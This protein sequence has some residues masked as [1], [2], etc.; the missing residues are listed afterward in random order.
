LR[1][2]PIDTNLVV[3]Y[4]LRDDEE[5]AQRTRSLLT[6]NRIALSKTVLLE[7]EWVLR[8]RYRLS[9]AEIGRGLRAVAELSHSVVEDEEAVARALDWADAGLDFADALHL[10][11]AGDADAFAS[12]DQRLRKRATEIGTRPL[13]IEP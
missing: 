5:Q 12:F 13:I 10:A 3:R 2:I 6:C 1:L 9:W 8:S 11:S 7:C 4:L